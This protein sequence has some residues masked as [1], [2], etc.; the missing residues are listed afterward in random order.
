MGEITPSVFTNGGVTGV[1]G[2]WIFTFPGKCQ[3]TNAHLIPNISPPPN[4]S[5]PINISPE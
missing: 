1:P 3:I 2:V 4:I 5:A